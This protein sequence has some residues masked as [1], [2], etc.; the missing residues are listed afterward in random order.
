VQRPGLA[1]TGFVAHF[2]K[3]RVQVLGFSE[4]AYLD[5][6]ASEELRRTL[7][8]FLAEEPPC[9]VLTRGLDA[10]AVLVELADTLHVPLF[11]T[12]LLNSTFIDRAADFLDQQ[13][14]QTT[15]LHAGL[16][17]VLGVGVLLVG[18]SGIG[19]SEV[20]LDLVIRGHRLVADDIV[21][22][23]KK[24]GALYGGP[25]DVIRHHMEIRGLGIIDV[26]A[27]FGVTA[28]RMQ[29]KVDL[30]VEL[31]T[32]DPARE[33]ERLGVD[34]Q[35]HEILGVPIPKVTL[36]L[37]AGR[38]VSA[39]VEVA[40]RDRLLKAQGIHSARDFRDQL[41]RAIADAHPERESGEDVE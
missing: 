5:S 13:L 16:V 26:K 31:V 30:E 4:L 37:R 19:K 7:Q 15:S 38:I 14:S 8:V 3:E 40:A 24:Q 21:E 27:L 33:Y 39:L 35:Y 6:L 1:I 34:E 11:V 32:W 20:A 28:I 10:P 36:P 23:R 25:S 12:P 29:K 17:D 2:R 22:L 9:V 41:S 18:P